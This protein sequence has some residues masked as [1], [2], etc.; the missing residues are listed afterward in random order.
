M[1]FD[2]DKAALA[3]IQPLVDSMST[4]LTTFSGHDGKLVFYHG[5]SDPW[6]SPFDTFDY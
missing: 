3:E 1:A 2:V 6:F 4:N 5:N